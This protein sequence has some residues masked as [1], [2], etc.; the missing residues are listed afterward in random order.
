MQQ[1]PTYSF[2]ATLPDLDAGVFEQKVSSAVKDVALG[3]V[4]YGDKGKKGKV[5]IELTLSRIG[6]SNQVNVDHR[7]LKVQPTKR[8]KL[9]EEDTTSTALYVGNSGAVSVIPN[10]QG[11]LWTVPEHA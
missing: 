6:D 3:T 9:T 2:V 4:L 8:G 10:T 7:V 11:Q 5:T 1:Q